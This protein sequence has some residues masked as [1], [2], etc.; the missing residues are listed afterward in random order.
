METESDYNQCF[1]TISGSPSELV[2]ELAAFVDVVNG[3]VAEDEDQVGPLTA[4][5]TQ[6]ILT[7]DAEGDSEEQAVDPEKFSQAIALV[8]G[9]AGA[10]EKASDKEFEPAYNLLFYVLTF[11]SAGVEGHLS[12]VLDLLSAASASHALSTLSV[13]T[14]LF[15]LLPAT[16]PLRKTVFGTVLSVTVSTKNTDLLIPQ[17][18][19]LPIWFSEWSLSP[20]EQVAT[21]VDIASTLEPVDQASALKYF[22]DAHS[23]AAAAGVTLPA[24]QTK[25]FIVLALSVPGFF[26]YDSIYAVVSSLSTVDA[27]HLGLL[28]IFVNGTFADFKAVPEA[29]VTGA[30]MDVE[31]LTKKIRLL[32]LA[33]LAASSPNLTVSYAAISS[34][35]AIDEEEVEFWIIDVIRAGLLEGKMSQLE[36]KLFVHRVVPRTFG[37]EQWEDIARR[38]QTWKTS[39]KDVL[40]VLRNARV[41]VESKAAALNAERERAAAAAA[42]AVAAAAVP[43]NGE[44]SA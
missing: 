40:V 4:E 1:F 21:L 12:T 33:S 44:V 8:L 16:S 3:F 36:Q 22:K 5:V 37:A 17:L 34:A 32:T 41:S 35:L 28:K 26:D 11:T 18:K 19:Q 43:A 30:G 29:T 9:A 23:E 20:E 14:N 39:L 15:N 7:E 31:V 2:A 13:L 6:L 25:K 42:S 10:F 27:G 38:L 24:E